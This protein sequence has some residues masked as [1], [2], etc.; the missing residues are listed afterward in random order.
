MKV[1]RGTYIREPDGATQLFYSPYFY[2]DAASA[3]RRKSNRKDFSIVVDPN[4]R[5]SFAKAFGNLKPGEYEESYE[6]S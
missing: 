3:F 4:E 2:I 6:D 1:R 5:D